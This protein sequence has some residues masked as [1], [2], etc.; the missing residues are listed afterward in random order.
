M[1]L[2]IDMILSNPDPELNKTN[3]QGSQF[4]LHIILRQN[5]ISDKKTHKLK[6]AVIFELL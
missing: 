5:N 4:C 1:D 2:I 6:C 3:I